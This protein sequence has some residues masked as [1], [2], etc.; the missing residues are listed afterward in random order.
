MC[1]VTFFTLYSNVTGSV[2]S[3]KDCVRFNNSGRYGSRKQDYGN[4]ACKVAFCNGEQ[5]QVKTRL[6]RCVA[7]W[8][9]LKSARLGYSQNASLEIQTGCHFYDWKNTTVADQ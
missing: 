4:Y 3:C 8:V 7:R 1:G 2:S 6:D 9:R 5:T